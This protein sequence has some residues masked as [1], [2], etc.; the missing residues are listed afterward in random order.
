M[1][2]KMIVAKLDGE[3]WECEPGWDNDENSVSGVD[4]ALPN[5]PAVKN[6]GVTHV[7][8]YHT[9]VPC[10]EVKRLR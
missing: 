5:H 7:Q 6:F 2:E 10:H 4:V 3:V 9:K 1:S 8:G